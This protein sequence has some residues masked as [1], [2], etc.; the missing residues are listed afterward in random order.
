MIVHKVVAHSSSSHAYSS[1]FPHLFLKTSCKRFFIHFYSRLKK[2][3]FFIR[4]CF[5]QE[6]ST[7]T[8]LPISLV[9]MSFTKFLFNIF[10][11]YIC[12][13]FARN[14]ITGVT[15]VRSND[16]QGYS[17]MKLSQIDFGRILI[18]LSR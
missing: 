2:L 15:F 6:Y 7:Q 1:C 13:H 11:L 9:F 17:Y 3:Q 8:D 5:L 4:M 16:D 18:I 12:V 14:S 10:L